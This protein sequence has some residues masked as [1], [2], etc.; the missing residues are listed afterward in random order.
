M[1][2]NQFPLIS[3]IIPVYNNRNWLEE[4]ID[5]VLKQTYSNYE[6]LII[7]DGST[8]N[9]GDLDVIKNESKI[10]YYKNTN[11][12]VAY[13][14]NF[15]VKIAKGLY[16]AFLD[17][18][19]FWS[20][21][22]LEKQISLMIT[23][24]SYCSQHSYKY[25]YDD[26]KNIKKNNTFIYHRNPKKFLF[27]SFK[28]Q[29]SSFMI[30]KEVFDDN[31]IKF[32]ENKTF[33]EDVTFYIELMKR[34]SL[35]CIDE[36][37][38]YFRIRNNNSGFDTKKQIL[39]RIEIFKEYGN[40][41]IFI[42]NTSFLTVFAYKFLFSINKIKKI[43]KIHYKALLNAIYFIPWSIFKIETLFLIKRGE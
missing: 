18:D 20:P 8:E 1:N 3:V 31:K 14:R 9:I 41:K 24:N 25:Y 28:V 16:V 12:G 29:T 26:S 37:L 34:Y 32:D 38:A 10:C 35:L 27:R 4:A 2:N 17:S 42:D 15:G 39:S 13:S 5:S 30:K 11:H 36:Y 43:E 40:E 19:D 23:N 22:K 33:G 21:N 7:D 6:I